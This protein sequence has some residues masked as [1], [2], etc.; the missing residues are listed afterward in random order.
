MELACRWS[1]QKTPEADWYTAAAAH[2]PTAFI[3]HTNAF[4]F[5]HTFVA[6][7]PK[8]FLQ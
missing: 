7:W 5:F 3:Y 4:R 2:T 6:A 8:L 1:V